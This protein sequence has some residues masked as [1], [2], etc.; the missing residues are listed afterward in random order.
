MKR[1]WTKRER[2]AIDRLGDA[3]QNER[4]A[5]VVEGYDSP[6]HVDASARANRAGKA[7]LQILRRR[8]PDRAVIAPRGKGGAK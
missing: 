1:G 2:A 6:W 3:L 5:I 4:D 7:V 8:F